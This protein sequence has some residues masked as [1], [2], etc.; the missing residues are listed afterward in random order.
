MYK[1]TIT[2]VFR[3]TDEVQVEFDDGDRGRLSRHEA[4]ACCERL[5]P[6]FTAQMTRNGASY[7]SAYTAASS[8]APCRRA[9]SPLLSSNAAA[10]VDGPSSSTSSSSSSLSHATKHKCP[11]CEKTFLHP[12]SVS[13]HKSTC[14]A[15]ISKTD[16]EKA[17]LNRL[18]SMGPSSSPEFRRQGARFGSG[19]NSRSSASFSASSASSGKRRRHHYD[20]DDGSNGYSGNAGSSLQKRRLRASSAAATAADSAAEA[21]DGIGAR[22]TRGSMQISRYEARDAELARQ[23]AD[24]VEV[25]AAATAVFEASAGGPPSSS[26]SRWVPLSLQAGG[27]GR[28]APLTWKRR[29]EQA[30]DRVRYVTTL[31]PFHSFR[32]WSTRGH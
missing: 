11:A 31:S 18:N 9:A 17:E 29:A 1:G 13:G 2:K 26:N 12:R 6:G 30:E 22:V 28:M 16:D 7:I 3:D 24:R 32:F 8:P 10:A 15:W 4:V 21:V 25:A 19:S 14:A 5:N 20:A 27:N 23:L